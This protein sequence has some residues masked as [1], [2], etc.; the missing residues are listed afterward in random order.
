MSLDA[1]VAR[2]VTGNRLDGAAPATTVTTT[3]TTAFGAAQTFATGT[4]PGS[5]FVTGTITVDQVPTS[6]PAGLYTST[7]TF[8]IS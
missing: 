1:P 3:P 5:V 6:V 8:T 4:G 7:V 2:Y